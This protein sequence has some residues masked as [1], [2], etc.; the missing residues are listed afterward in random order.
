MLLIAACGG[1][2]DDGGDGG[3]GEE[4]TVSTADDGGGEEPT[5]LGEPAVPF[6]EGCQKSDETQFPGGPEVIIDTSKTYVATIKLAQGDIVLELF[7][8]VPVTT[9]NFV[10]LAC[11][12]YYD[13]VTF[14]RVIPDFVAQ[15]GDPTGTGSGGPGYSIPDEEDGDHGM[16]AG[17]ISMAKSGPNTTGSQFFITYTPQHQLEPTFTVF[18]RVTE[19]MDV[20]LQ[21]T[22]RTTPDLPPGDVIETITIEE[23]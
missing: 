18:G 22:P 10:F 8:D 2:D 11:K 21:I 19:G 4:P 1:D 5:G 15:G 23:R 17:V 9:N 16:D 3:I 20:A 14:H 12:G 7:S 6:A 13:G